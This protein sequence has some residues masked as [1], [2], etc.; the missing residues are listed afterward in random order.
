[1]SDPNLLP[2]SFVLPWRAIPKPRPRVTR[3][4]QHTYNPSEY[5][6]WKEAVAEWAVWKGIPSLHGQCR[7]DLTFGSETVHVRMIPVVGDRQR[8][9]YVTGDIDNLSGGV[10]DAL[11]DAD[12]L[13]NDRDVIELRSV[14]AERA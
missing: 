12:V 7:L 3:G 11:Q 10:M 1:M 9:L 6:E 14:I 13:D 8:A 2:R 4:G 5:T